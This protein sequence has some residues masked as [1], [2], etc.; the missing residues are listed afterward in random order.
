[1]FV[2]GSAETHAGH[3]IDERQLGIVKILF[4]AGHGYIMSSLLQAN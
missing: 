1:M 3:L 4:R 2:G